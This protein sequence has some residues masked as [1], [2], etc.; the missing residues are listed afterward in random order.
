MKYIMSLDQGTTSS[1]TLIFGECGHLH[2]L[3]QEEVQIY[4]PQKGFVEQNAMQLWQAQL[5]TMRQA[6][7]VSGINAHEIGAMGITNQRETTIFWHKKTGQA[8]APAIVWQDRRTH[9][10]CDR[11]HKKGHAA[12]IQ[13][14]T[15]LQPD[16]YFSASKVKW[17]LDHH[18]DA[19][20][21]A[22]EGKLAFGTV[23]SWLI[24]QLSG[25]KAHVTDVSNASRTM[26]FD[27]DKGQW[28]KQ[29]LDLFDIPESILPEVCP[30]G[31]LLAYTDPKWLGHA[32]PIYAAIGDQQS[33]L[34]G[35][36]CDRA[37]MAKN[38]YGTGCFLLL[39]TGHQR[40][41]S[42]HKLLSTVT[43]QQN[44]QALGYALEGS[45][46]MAGAIVQW[47]RDNLGIIQSSAEVESLA[48]QVPDTEGVTLVPAFTGLGAPHW[49]A[50]AQAALFGMSRGTHRAHIARAAL[51]AIAF[52][53]AD[54]LCAMQQDTHTPLTELRVDGGASANNLL[55]QFQADILGVPVLRPVM[56]EMTA[57]GAA[58]MAGLAAGIYHETESAWQLDRA[59]EP[60]MSEDERQMRLQQWHGAVQ[61]VL[62]STADSV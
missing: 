57:W 41:H 35:Q 42:K 54:V 62:V 11:W 2:G 7:Q 17:V 56:S 53:V 61:K 28:S 4:T 14:I 44:K 18:P 38:T 1:R 24:W 34:F 12:D 51:E 48:A 30:S 37:G 9:A 26:L 16:P 33:A 52:Q 25:A 32:I 3:A 21:L 55:M 29:L 15:G 43:W 6:L 31:S 19:K 39:N 36:G 13:A 5:Q 23:D 60:R 47:L 40:Q 20:R 8:I 50:Q 10:W 49:D 58:K 45:I 59:F 46:F 22:Q 27:L